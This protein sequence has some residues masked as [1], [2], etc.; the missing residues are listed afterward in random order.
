VE[1]VA[2]AKH[3]SLEALEHEKQRRMQ[4]KL[5][6]R[7]QKRQAAEQQ[8]ERQ[9]EH[10]ARLQATLDKYTA[11]GADTQA[12]QQD[13]EHTY[14]KSLLAGNPSNSVLRGR[15]AMYFRQAAEFCCCWRQDSASSYA[16]VT[17]CGCCCHSVHCADDPVTG[18]RKKR[19]GSGLADVEVEE[20]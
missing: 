4:G 15:S 18:K 10:E 12:G 7:I 16:A 3:G 1:D 19:F 9:Q 20:F 8:E 2:V 14:G 5:E 11:A 6:Q 13:G 17:C